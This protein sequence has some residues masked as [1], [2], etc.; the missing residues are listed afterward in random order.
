MHVGRFST[1][2]YNDDKFCDFCLLSCF[3]KGSTLKGTNLRK[4]F[5]IRVDPFSNFPFSE[6]RQKNY[7]THPHPRDPSSESVSFPIK[8]WKSREC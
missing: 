7:R 3:E 6:G 1:T 2:S 4:F 8:K 5:P